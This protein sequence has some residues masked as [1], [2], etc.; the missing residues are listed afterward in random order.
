MK[1]EIVNAGRSLPGAPYSPCVRA[2]CLLFISGQVP[3]DPDTGKLVE[4]GFEQQAWQC[5]NNLRVTLEQAGA[6][7]THVVKTTVFLSDLGNFAAMNEVYKSFFPAEPPARTAVQAA[8]LPM[9]A[10]IEIEAVAVAPD[11]D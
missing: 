4:G 11:T 8:R 6:S 2:G 5:L 1:K 7:M 10:M 3:L 9:D